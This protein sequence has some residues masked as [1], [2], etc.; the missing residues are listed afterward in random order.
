MKIQECVLLLFVWFHQR[1][2]NRARSFDKIVRAYVRRC[3]GWLRA[4]PSSECGDVAVSLRFN[5]S[6]K[7]DFWIKENLR[8]PRDKLDSVRVL[9][10]IPDVIHT[11]NRDKCPGFHAFLMLLYKLSWPRR[12][13]DLRDMF[14]GTKQRN[15]RIVNEV[16][17]FLFCRFRRKM[18]SMDRSRL[19]DDYL[20]MLCQV[21]YNKNQVMENIFGF[22]DGTVRPCCRPVR[23][24]DVVYNG[25]KKV[26]AI[27]FQSVVAWDGIIC[28]MNGPWVGSR[29]DSG[30]FVDS[31]LQHLLE[32][33]PCVQLGSALTPVA[34]YADDGYALSPRVFIPY[35][36][37]RTC[38]RHQA[39]NKTMSASR[40]T[41][42]W[43]YGRILALWRSLNFKD[44]QKI[45][46]SPIGAYYLVATILTNC[47]TCIEGGNAVTEYSGGRAPS[48][49]EYLLSLAD[50]SC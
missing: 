42:E 25:Y 41:V 40:V 18:A 19:N 9:L 11:T 35:P 24:Q 38:A 31:G 22:L 21:H 10:G 33:M 6:E 47:L 5:L 48:L 20:K 2:K 26:H 1:R 23:F 27:K 37:G 16:A 30:I 43:S 17:C 15:G 29:H 8:F 7:S 46:K 32:Q 12:T 50:E 4:F 13:S 39:F 36:D 45:F 14:G 34:L 3:G 28:H 49:E 44:N